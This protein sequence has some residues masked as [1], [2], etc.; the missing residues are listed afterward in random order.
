MQE[1][2]LVNATIEKMAI[3][4]KEKP[5]YTEIEAEKSSG[6]REDILLS[7][8]EPLEIRIKNSKSLFEQG[9]ISEEEYKKKLNE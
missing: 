1:G 8:K 2:E 7:D 4:Y 3:A 6:N 9:L 5:K